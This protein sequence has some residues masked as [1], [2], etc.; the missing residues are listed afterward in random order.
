M[1]KTGNIFVKQLFSIFSAP[2]K[3]LFFFVFGDYYRLL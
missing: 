2:L 3:K 1:H